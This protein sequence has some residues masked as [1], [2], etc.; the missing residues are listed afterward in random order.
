MKILSIITTLGLLFNYQAQACSQK[1]VEQAQASIEQTKLEIQ[2]SKASELDL[3][4][5]S[6]NWAEAKLCLE[7]DDTTALE[8][9]VLNEE[10][11]VDY[12]QSLYNVGQLSKL[13]LDKAR[14]EIK[15]QG[16]FCLNQVLPFV[17]L[18]YNYG[19]K[20]KAELDQTETLCKR[21]K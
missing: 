3:A 11:K 17:Q 9:L 14:T 19:F 4:I 10:K 6:I 21:L 18:R 13:A 1:L 5:L 16:N 8:V 2:Y 15:F 7:A 12:L 20:S